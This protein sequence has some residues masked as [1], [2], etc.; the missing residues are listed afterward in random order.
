MI[1]AF[2]NCELDA[3]RRE[4]RRGGILV[5]VEPQIFDLLEY[6]IRHR[7][8]VVSRDDL[9]TAIWK[10]RVVS[11]STLGSR[12][13]AVRLAIGDDGTEQRLVKTLTRKGFRYVGQV[14][15]RDH[16]T[17]LDQPRTPPLLPDKPSVAVLPFTN[18]SGDPEQAY[19]ADGVAE[20]I[21]TALCRFPSLFVIAR[22]SSF[23]YRGR[24]IDIR[25]VGR[26]LG[27]RYVLEGS[28]RR[29][30]N[31]ARV[32]GQL[33]EAATGNHLWAEQYDGELTDIFALQDRGTEA[34][35]GAIEPSIRRAEVERVRRIPPRS[36]NAYDLYLQGLPLLNQLGRESNERAQALFEQAI[37]ADPTFVPAMRGAAIN[38]VAA[39]GQE[40]I[41]R[42]DAAPQVMEHT[43][44]ALELAPDDAHT[45][46]SAAHML[47]WYRGCGGSTAID[48]AVGMADQAVALNP[49]AIHVLI[50]S[51]WVQ[52]HAGQSESAIRLYERALRLSPKD[53]SAFN[54]WASLSL[55]FLQCGRD[56]DAIVAAKTALRYGPRWLI[57]FL[58]LSSAL[59]L[60][61]RL[62]EARS[63]TARLL[64]IRPEYRSRDFREWAESVHPPAFSRFLEGLRL[65]GVPE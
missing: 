23:G 47:M 39:V 20:D 34:V 46:A 60:A 15:V 14:T 25:R 9:M 61:G 62:G 8:R 36:F 4:L 6:L 33:I 51:G 42:W 56:Q 38:L 53:P 16:S 29:A 44:R 3:G 27:V 28:V 10:D 54:V 49:N 11:E 13:N 17:A 32:T 31:R 40:W 55:A 21:I 57:S 45:L 41:S 35:A 30:G 43:R 65:A 7:E 52:L 18:M 24:E 59:A 63:V 1:Y 12:I 22:N 64:E 58:R 19:F 50:Y 37:K 48:E 26:E 2:E 5:P